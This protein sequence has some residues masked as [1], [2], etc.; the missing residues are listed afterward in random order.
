MWLFR[1]D[2]L[3]IQLASKDKGHHALEIQRQSLPLL[4]HKYTHPA[5]THTHTPLWERGWGAENP[6]EP[7]HST[8]RFNICVDR[9]LAAD[10][11]ALETAREDDR[12]MFKT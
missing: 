12:H 4:P 2:H 3:P 9:T 1:K 6:G 8:S 5:H 7:C 11:T 10:M